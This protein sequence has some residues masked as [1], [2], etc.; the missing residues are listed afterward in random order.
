MYMYMSKVVR[1]LLGLIMPD[2][3][4]LSEDGLSIGIVKSLYKVI[5]Q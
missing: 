5:F 1:D 4:D 3:T 2:I